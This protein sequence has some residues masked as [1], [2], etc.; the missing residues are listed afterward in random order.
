MEWIAVFTFGLVVLLALPVARGA[1]AQP[2]LGLQAV[3]AV[4][5]LA[6]CVLF[7]AVG[8]STG[9]A[10]GAFA[11]AAIG[12]LCLVVGAVWLTS[13]QHAVSGPAQQRHEETEAGF[14]GAE[15]LMFALAATFALLTALGVA[16]LN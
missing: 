7:I 8:G 3:A 6:L 12:L 1:A 15:L 2:A 10:W 16:T 5:G 13:D 14:A 9:V 11:A 4:A